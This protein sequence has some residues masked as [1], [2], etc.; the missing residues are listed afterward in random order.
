MKTCV[1]ISVFLLA[2]LLCLGCFASCKS[3][4]GNEGTTTAPTSGGSNP[5]GNSNQVND[6]VVKYDYPDLDCG[7]ETIRICGLSWLWDM[8]IFLDASNTGD[9]LD[10][11]IYNRN[12]WIEET[13]K[14]TID[15]KE[16]Q[17]D[18][19]M[20]E[21]VDSIQTAI[22]GNASDVWDI[23]YI[24]LNER[25]DLI[26]LGYFNDLNTIKELQL[27]RPWWDTKLNNTLEL[28]GSL[29][30]ASSPTQLQAF[31]SAWAIFFNETLIANQ[32]GMANP[33]DLFANDEWTLEKMGQMC[34]DG[35]TLNGAE[36]YYYSDG[37]GKQIYGIS[38][39]P[40]LPDKL[41]YAAG[42]RYVVKNENT[43]VPEFRADGENFINVVKEMAKILGEEHNL[44]ASSD[45]MVP[46][47]N[48]YYG[49]TCGYV[50]AF[51]NGRAFF[52]GGEIKTARVIKS[53]DVEVSYGIL[54]LPKW[55]SSQKEY[56]TPVVETLLCFAI[57]TTCKS[58]KL[59][60][61]AQIAD[62]M[63]YESYAKVLPVYYDQLLHR[64]YT[65][66]DEPIMDVLNSSR[67]VDMAYYYGWNEA[68]AN[69]IQERVFDGTAEISSI[70]GSE[71]EN[72]E[73]AI[74]KWM[75]DFSKLNNKA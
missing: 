49:D 55:S 44:H 34:E 60:M 11:A 14:C 25:P 39:H 27:D 45:D 23:V 62:I 2:L 6:N 57:P 58:E 1:R 9:K 31:D 46:Q 12:A 64:G 63:S 21:Y 59:S 65:E 16:F 13:F 4:K 61:V 30:S 43:G 24:P 67:G 22:F 56:Y 71:K 42:E 52:M 41:L 32:E 19:S 18:W 51:V 47:Q 15:V 35:A 48:T 28:S 50:Y 10:Q 72:I 33:R 75:E 3:G 20:T 73:K 7:G 69:D 37:N 70:L 53:Q 54:P 36:S 66:A 17:W 29:Y 40:L 38:A 74:K 5:G 26:T 8:Y 68:L